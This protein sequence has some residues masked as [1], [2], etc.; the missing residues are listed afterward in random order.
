MSRLFFSGRALGALV[1][2]LLLAVPAVHA[3]SHDSHAGHD[4]SGHD[5]HAAEPAEHSEDEEPLE[6]LMEVYDKTKTHSLDGVELKNLFTAIQ[7]KGGEAEADD[8]H[9]GHAH[10][11]PA[12]T[13]A[14]ATETLTIKHI[15]EHYGGKGAIA[16]NETAFVT[17]C[18]AMLKC[19]SE[20][21]CEFEHNEEDAHSEEKKD[22]FEH[23]GLKLGVLAAILVLSLIGGLAPSVLVHSLVHA[24]G[25]MSLLNAFS[26]G[27]F[28][29]AGLTH[30]LPHVVETSMDVD[31]GD[32]PLPY[33]LVMLGYML[34]FLVERVVF[35]TH[36]HSVD[37]ED[38]HAAHCHGDHGHLGEGAEKPNKS[39]SALYNSLV[40]LFA[41]SLHAILAGVS[42]GLQ[43]ERKNVI[44]LTVA[45]CSHKLFAAF[46]IG[47]KF[48]RSGMPVKHVVLLVVIFSLVTP[49]GIAIGIGVGTADP[50]VKLILEG[51][52]A[53][54][55]IYIGATE[56][57]AD[58]FETAARACEIS[59][60]K[61][62]EEKTTHAHTHRV[63]AAPGRAARLGAFSA[64]ALGVAVILLA[65]L[66]PHAEH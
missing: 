39:N 43:S 42:L 51:L 55:F 30:I 49:V 19:A 45:I 16:L 46:S 5:D 22:S 54:T 56:I 59:H 9:A 17:A 20:A 53:G 33:A 58:E 8:A 21:S 62:D 57:T 13:P 10:A 6:H 32:Y 26:G 41:I 36:G 64:Y 60:G 15:L 27:V 4:H 7:E 48:I 47:T 44:T 34:I 1:V 2:A 12:A 24:D 35:H 3:T 63:H 38:E 65:N 28:L 25:V 52:A 18:P 50:V 23:L 37:T 14:A 31:H 61:T 40:V 11:A 29:T 66:A